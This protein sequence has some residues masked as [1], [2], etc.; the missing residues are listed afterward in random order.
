MSEPTSTPAQLPKFDVER[1]LHLSRQVVT[2]GVR[3]EV[4][5]YQLVTG[6]HGRSRAALRSALASLLAHSPEEWRQVATCF[7]ES[8]SVESAPTSR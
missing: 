5:V 6:P 1:F 3:E 4:R 2:V 7:E 8:F